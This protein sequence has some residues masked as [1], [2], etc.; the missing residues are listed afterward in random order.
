MST[1][2]LDDLQ[3][4]KRELGQIKHKVDYLLES[5]ERMEKDH[6]KRSGR[7]SQT[8]TPIMPCGIVAQTAQTFVDWELVKNLKHQ[9][10]LIEYNEQCLFCL[11]MY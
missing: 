2:R 7:S 3:T 5:L 6:G 11:Y 10:L 1:V 9:V 4:I 8:P